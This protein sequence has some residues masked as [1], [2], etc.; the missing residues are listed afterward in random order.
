MCYGR[1]VDQCVDNGSKRQRV[2]KG[3]FWG[4]G[5]SCWI[6]GV[7]LSMGLWFGQNYVLSLLSLS[8]F[9]TFQWRC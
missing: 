7:V 1:R 3:E 2:I 4:L 5:F 8:C 9:F 6:D